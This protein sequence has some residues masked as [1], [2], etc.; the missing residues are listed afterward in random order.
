M[1]SSHTMSSKMEYSLVLELHRKRF[2]D[3]YQASF[4]LTKMLA[5]SYSL[6]KSKTSYCSFGLLLKNTPPP[7]LSVNTMQASHSFTLSYLSKITNLIM[8]LTYR[9]YSGTAT[10][11]A[12]EKVQDP[13]H[14]SWTLSPFLASSPFSSLK[15]PPV[16]PPQTLSLPDTPY[17]FI[18]PC[19]WVVSLKNT[20]PLFS[21]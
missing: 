4:H 1:C 16:Q 2:G 9:R 5:K 18:F 17:S 7:H 8:S 15:Y 21:A 6:C 12:P 10:Y 13:R 11:G 20:F 19:F 3:E 14:S